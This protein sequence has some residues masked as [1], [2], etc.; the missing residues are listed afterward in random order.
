MSNDQSKEH[1]ELFTPESLMGES[2]SSIEPYGVNS[3]SCLAIGVWLWSRKGIDISSMRGAKAR[4][5]LDK[6]ELFDFSKPQQRK[7]QPLLGR[8]YKQ[9]EIDQIAQ[10][11]ANFA[12]RMSKDEAIE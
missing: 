6:L 9:S 3:T 10:Y 1:P 5:Y 8:P 4:A 12:I 2:L 11:I 7:A